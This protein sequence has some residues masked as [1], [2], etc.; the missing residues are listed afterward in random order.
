MFKQDAIGMPFAP[1]PTEPSGVAQL[2]GIDLGVV[3][4]GRNE[5]PRLVVCLDSIAPQ[6]DSIVYVDSGSTDGSVAAAGARGALVV[7]LSTARPF[8]AARARND[9]FAVLKAARPTLLYVQF[10]DGDCRMVDGWLDK[11]STFLDQHADVAIVCGRRREIYPAASIYNQVLDLEWDTPVGQTRACGGDFLVRR[12][13][14]EQV[15]G[16]RPDLIA[17]EEPELCT[18][19]AKLG[20]KIWRLD[21]EMTLH[22][23]AIKRF[24]QWWNRAVRSG[25]GTIEVSLLHRTSGFGVWRRLVLSNIFWSCYLPFCLLMSI[26]VH[27]AVLAALLLYPVQICRMAIARGAGSKVSW[28]YAALT[29]L[30]KFA[31]MQGTMRYVLLRSRGRAATLIEYK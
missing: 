26:F 30:S 24:G 14:F 1:F 15:G 10:I 31:A 27:P 12:E 3:A 6:A 19:L 18:R 9:G 25:Y 16:F 29:L 5:G 21:A 23:A 28:T 11:A 8:S 17:G 7:E 2:P 4:I 20:W 13:A 22:D